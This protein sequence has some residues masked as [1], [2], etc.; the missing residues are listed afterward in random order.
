MNKM[1]LAIDFLML[2]KK[3]QLVK[4]DKVNILGLANFKKKSIKF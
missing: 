4:D 2:E 3:Y 1:N